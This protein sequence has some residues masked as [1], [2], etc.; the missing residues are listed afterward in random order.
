[1]KDSYQ[2]FIDNFNIDKN[3]FYQYGIKSIISADFDTAKKQYER[4][5]NKLINNGSLTIRSYGRGGKNSN[6]YVELYKS[7]FR[8]NNIKIDPT[9]NTVPR[10]NISDATNLKIN[11]NLSNYQVSHIWGKTK[12]PVLFESVWNICF[13]P[14]IF[15]PFTGHE[16]KGGWNDDFIPMLKRYV[17]DKFKSIIIDYNQFVLNNCL[18]DKINEFSN[19]LLASGKYDIKLIER[20]RIDALAEW[21]LITKS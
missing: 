10:K 7:L 2:E 5:K 6:L 8:N 18:Q 12:N 1:M 17:Y 14:R 19:S 21:G 4:V 20:F 9:N 15:D 11:D 13:I 16:C 3:D